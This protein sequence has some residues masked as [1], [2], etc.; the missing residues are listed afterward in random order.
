LLNNFL[1]TF[2]NLTGYTVGNFT[3]EALAGRTGAGVPRWKVVCKSCGDHL[4]LDHA[5]LMPLIQGS[6]T[7]VSLQCGNAVCP[8]SRTV[9]NSESFHD[10]RRQ[11][12][13]QAAEAE[14][15][16]AEVARAA[17]A[18]AAIQR[19]AHADL[20]ALKRQYAKFYGHQ[21]NTGV[22]GEIFPWERFRKLSAGSRKIIM[23][24]LA[25]DPTAFIVSI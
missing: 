18:Q 10:L 6:R 14:A 19:A 1:G 25:A 24:K 3:V 8:A 4:T 12:R 11:E 13:E 5:I 20:T 9:D 2:L 15:Q 7:Q 16:A 21:C 22:P 17:Q 23:D